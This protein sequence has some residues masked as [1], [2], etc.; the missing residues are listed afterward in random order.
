MTKGLEIL[1]LNPEPWHHHNGITCRSGVI[2]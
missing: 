1:A 2:S